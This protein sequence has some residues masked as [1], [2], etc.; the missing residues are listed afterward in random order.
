MK[1]T[2]GQFNAGEIYKALK[3]KKL[4]IKTVNTRGS[5]IELEFTK[6]LTSTQI[7][8]V[9]KVLFAITKAVE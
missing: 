1:Y 4:P 9:N 5:T 6:E 3:G 7:A 8:E 2:W